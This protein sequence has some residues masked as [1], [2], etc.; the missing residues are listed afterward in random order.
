MSD[1]RRAVLP[2][3]LKK[4]PCWIPRLLTRFC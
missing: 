3:R 1:W 4:S 2:F